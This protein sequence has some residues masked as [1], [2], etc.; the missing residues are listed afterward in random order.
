MLDVSSDNGD[1]MTVW[2]VSKG[3]AVGTPDGQGYAGTVRSLGNG[4]TG[5][6]L[7]N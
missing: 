2:E 5:G 3:K 4:G 6:T 1:E 7:G